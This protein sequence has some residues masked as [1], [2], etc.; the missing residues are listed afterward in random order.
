MNLDH[1]L[2][3]IQIFQ[4]QGE[5][6]EK[7]EAEA[8]EKALPF[9]VVKIALAN[10]NSET[11]PYKLCKKIS[12]DLTDLSNGNLDI[13]RALPTQEKDPDLHKSLFKIVEIYKQ[14][15]TAEK[16]V[17]VD[18]KK[19]ELKKI[20][21]LLL[22]VGDYYKSMAVALQSEQIPV[23]INICTK[24]AEHCEIDT[25][26][27]LTN[28]MQIDLNNKLIETFIEKIKDMGNIYQAI[29]FADGL[30]G[31]YQGRLAF[32]L[33]ITAL[34]ERGDIDKVLEITNNMYRQKLSTDDPE[35]IATAL[36]KNGNL[37]KAL[38]VAAKF[39]QNAS[40]IVP[41]AVKMVEIGDVDKTYYAIYMIDND[42]D[43]A[44][45][46][47]I[48]ILLRIGNNDDAIRFIRRMTKSSKKDDI[49]SNIITNLFLLPVSS[50]NCEKATS[51]AGTITD[52]IKQGVA[53]ARITNI[54]QAAQGGG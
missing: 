29:K 50:S 22:E 9:D 52:P 38:E 23:F 30:T 28:E 14:L 51:I 17:E 54:I 43:E 7:Q 3:N 26:I 10:L 16:I 40:I 2:P 24:M 33:V 11:A 44:I 36:I 37:D 20:S 41:I 35:K 13:L 15:N 18:K 21:N 8:K 5:V 47:I 6:K 42:R 39:Y 46:K 31:F 53:L 4:N 32:N 48:N 1:L 25:A 34:I 27:T 49:I 12:C 19:S 45:E